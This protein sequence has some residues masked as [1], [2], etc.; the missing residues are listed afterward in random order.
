MRADGDVMGK[1]TT[2]VVHLKDGTRGSVERWQQVGSEAHALVRLDGGV[3]A[4]VPMSAL[5]PQSDGVY[6]LPLD[7]TH[8]DH[9]QTVIPVLAEEVAIGR[10]TVETGTVRLRKVVHERE[11][12]VTPTVTREVVQVER[13]PVGRVL[14]GPVAPRQEGDTLVV[15]VFEERLVVEKRLVLVEELRITRRRED[16]AA[17]PQ[18]VTLRREEVVVERE[19]PGEKNTDH[20]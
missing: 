3:R 15:P 7:R 17:A 13:V 9:T 19:T 16:V 18:R 8:F 10:R 4:W 5:V 6:A 1:Q 20:T 11:E 12:V 2:P 14:E